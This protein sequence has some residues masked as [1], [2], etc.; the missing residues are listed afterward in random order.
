MRSLI[1]VD[2]W[3]IS[4][5]TFPLLTGARVQ[6]VK[7]A[8]SSPKLSQARKCAEAEW[9]RVAVSLP[10]LACGEASGRGRSLRRCAPPDDVK[11]TR[12][13]RVHA[14]RMTSAGKPLPGM[15]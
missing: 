3:E 11:G 6:A 7:A 10:S 14:R 2:L 12:L 15:R 1:A 9:G 5:V 8:S 4:I 13:A